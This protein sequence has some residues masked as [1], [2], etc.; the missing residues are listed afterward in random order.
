MSALAHPKVLRNI[1]ALRA[2]AALLVVWEHLGNRQSGI[3]AHY[4]SGQPVF[5]SFMNFGLFGVDIFFVISGFIIYTTTATKRTGTTTSLDFF[6]RRC[7]RIYPAY[8]LA[9]I[10]LLAV[11]VIAPQH[12]TQ[13]HSV[14][15]N[16][17]AS[18][19]LLPQVG[20][21]FL[22]VSWTL[23]FEMYFYL[24]FAALL[25]AQRK[26]M[27]PGLVLWLGLQIVGFAVLRTASGAVPEFF[28]NPIA[29]EFIFGVG[30]G[31]LYARNRLPAPQ[32][33]FGIA[34]LACAALW[35]V[36]DRLGDIPGTERIFLWGIPATG[37]VYGAVAIESTQRKT[38][39]R[40]AVS[41][42]DASYALYLWHLPV[43]IFL[44][45]VAA[46]THIHTYAA[47]IAFVVAMLAAVIVF[48][49]GVYRYLE[50]P[51]TRYLN[52]LI[53]IQAHR[54]P[55]RTEIHDLPA[56]TRPSREVH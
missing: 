31:M 35:I 24:I 23:V 36:A 29:V 4:L 22:A 51:L 50:R 34:L 30:I 14:N 2:A 56:I 20:H 10:P 18:F 11:Y 46:A 19:L 49:L 16:L 25:L 3:E 43:L 41:L 52:G 13:F 40:W 27:L 44:G 17:W 12:F 5:A 55:I 38:A 8:W 48:S 32:I 47:H 1:Q 6:L 42:G 28:A 9:F 7:I 39:P 53:R 26:I 21:P 33:V 45:Q 37:L 54:A 15:M